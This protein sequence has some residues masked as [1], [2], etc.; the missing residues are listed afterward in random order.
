MS[1]I[2][3]SIFNNKRYIFFLSLTAAIFVAFIARLVD[4]QVINGE[5]YKLR[6]NSSNIYF[7]KTDAVRG[8]IFDCNGVGLAINETGYKLVIDRILIDKG[9]ENELI[10]RVVKLLETLKN[11]WID[12]LPINLNENES[13]FADDRASQVADLKNSLN[14]PENA[15]AE[16]CLNKLAEKYDAKS[17]SKPDQRIICSVRYNMDKNGS[18][19][20]KTTPYIISDGISKEAVIII[21]EKA[22]ELKGVRI[23]TSLVRKYIN[24][25]IA[26]HIVGYTGF[27][28][29]EEYEKRKETYS[30]D[31]LIGKTGV[32]SIFE[33]YLRGFGGKRMIQMSPSG[34]VINVSEK[35]PAKSGNS[36]ILTISS[37]LQEAANKSLKENVE[38]AHKQGAPDCVSGAV[39][40]LNVKD[41]SVLA[42]ATYPSYDLVR[43]M[44]DKSYYSELIKDSATP[45]LNRAFSGAYA[46]GSTYKPLVV[47]A[48]LQSGKVTPENAVR[49]T[50]SY[51][52]YHGYHL[53]CMGVHGNIKLINA[54]SKSCNVY[55]AEMGRRLGAELLGDYAKKFGVG[56]KTGVEI[57]ESK[58]IVAGPE[59][60][61]SVGS[62]WYESGSSQAAIG[63]SDNMLTP[64]QLATYTATIASGGNRYKTHLVSKIMD[65]TRTKAVKEFEPE[66]V[67]NVGVSAENLNIVKTGMREVALSGTAR[68][69][70]SYPIPIA[71]KT[72]TAQ[73]SGSDHTTFI[74][75][76]P[77][78]DP[79]IAIAVVIAHGKTGAASK[80]VARDIMNSYF[81]LGT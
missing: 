41:F 75:F 17:F 36:V 37:K 56:V 57:G 64:L 80:N 30:M 59:H 43:F 32:E 49:C 1:R 74:C 8:E 26:P 70:A 73:N 27:M 15:S 20:A 14:L 78:D 22:E 28:S 10:I 35:E 44:E 62:K 67:Q 18:Y 46:P 5:Y 51:N 29:S 42:A 69:F 54:L 48:A 81:N 4:W 38:K 68:D 60:S 45:L 47:C 72:G 50:G 61:A 77:Y 52:F 55:F 7:V 24:G 19:H 31:A 2:K 23:Q 11:S 9:K 6:A 79:K 39:V 40:A 25:G 21:S 12:I 66:L 33:D 65:Y 13:S 58:G 3:S 63:Q 16:E 71:A 76:A 34:Q 53:R